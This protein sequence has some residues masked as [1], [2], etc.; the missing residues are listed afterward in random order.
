[1]KLGVG[2][3]PERVWRKRAIAQGVPRTTVAMR[4]A[5][6][7]K[8]PDLCRPS[9]SFEEMGEANG[10]RSYK[11]S[12]S[13]QEPNAPGWAGTV[14]RAV[15]AAEGIRPLARHLGCNP[16]LVGRWVR[17]EADPA[18]RWHHVLIELGGEP[19][20]ADAIR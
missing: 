19:H 8:G 16:S 20:E 6:G 18:P 11:R 1:M 2:D 3:I 15:R 17:G 5:R 7:V 14:R 12:M 10:R 4:V 9:M 13:Y